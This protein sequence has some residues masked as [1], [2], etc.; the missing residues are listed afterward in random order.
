[1]L[2]ERGVF[3]EQGQEGINPQ[4]EQLQ[5]GGSFDAGGADAFRIE[6]GTLAEERR[7]LELRDE[8][9]PRFVFPQYF[10]GT[11]LKQV[12]LAADLSLPNHHGAFFDRL[13]ANRLRNFLQLVLAQIGE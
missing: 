13:R 10:D 6:Q 8:V 7:R 3:A 12:Y 11:A 5:V 4:D 9:A 1:M 2:A